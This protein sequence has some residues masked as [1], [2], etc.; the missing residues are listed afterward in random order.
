MASA[1][2]APNWYALTMKRPLPYSV[3]NARSICAHRN[4]ASLPRNGS[5]MLMPVFAC[6]KS[7]V[8]PP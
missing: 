3:W 6:R 2:P 7:G 5:K 1:L 8:T 4:A